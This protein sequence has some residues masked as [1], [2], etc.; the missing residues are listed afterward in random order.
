M[1]DYVIIVGSGAL[2]GYIIGILAVALYCF[3]C[4]RLNRF[5]VNSFVRTCLAKFVFRCI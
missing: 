4:N 1:L 5:V 3:L 2:R